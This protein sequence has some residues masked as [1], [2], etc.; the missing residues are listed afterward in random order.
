[1]FNPLI[2]ADINTFVLNLFHLAFSLASLV[3]V[4]FAF[5]VV[6]QIAVMRKTLITTFSPVFTLMG[7]IHLIFAFLVALIFIIGL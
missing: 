3:Y 2:G 5:V 1:M 6:R 7:Y 4:I